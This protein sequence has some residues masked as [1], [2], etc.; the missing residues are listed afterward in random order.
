MS[1]QIERKIPFTPQNFVKAASIHHNLDSY[2]LQSRLS[3]IE[4]SGLPQEQWLDVL[5]KTFLYDSTVAR[6]KYIAAITEIFEAVRGGNILRARNT[7]TRNHPK[8]AYERKST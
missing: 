3:I 2:E 4:K 6:K 8:P 7:V 1:P 5:S